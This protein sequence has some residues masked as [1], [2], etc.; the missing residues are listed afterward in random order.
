MKLAVSKGYEIVKVHEIWEYKVTQYDPKTGLGG[1]FTGYINM[2]LKIKAEASG[3]PKTCKTP[4]EKQAYI[5]DYYKREGILLE[6]SKIEYNSALR[7]LAKT[8][9]NSFWD[10]TVGQKSKKVAKNRLLS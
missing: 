8:Q 1:L 2:F 6:A 7:Q 3:W 4:E 5:D 9:I 10:R